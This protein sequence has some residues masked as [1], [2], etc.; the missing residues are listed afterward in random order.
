MSAVESA[1][2]PLL[3]DDEGPICTLTLNRPQQRNALSMGVMV[4]LAQ[5]LDRIASDSRIKVVLLTGNG[6]AFCS[7]HDLKEMHDNRSGAFYKAVFEQCS[8][9]MQKI[10]TLPQPVIA[11]VNGFA[12]AAGCQLVA[13]CDLALAAEDAKF[14]TPG[15]NIGLFCSTPMVALSRNV[16]RKH[17]MEMLLL[18]EMIDARKAATIGLIN[19]C[20]PPEKLHEAAM[21]WARTIAS[22]ASSTVKTGKRAFYEQLELHL[23][24]AYDYAS[25]VMTRNMLDPDATE[26]IDAFLKKRQPNWKS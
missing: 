8:A 18:G 10:V 12:F 22:K 15:V 17:A 23:A 11:E 6:P 3:R 25:A 2:S 7:G 1:V 14:S 13:S 21:S 4:A 24:D 5:E 16:S 9:M 26:G 19:R 20:V